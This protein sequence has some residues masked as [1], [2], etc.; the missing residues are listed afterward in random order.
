MNLL[1]KKEKIIDDK[2]GGQKRINMSKE[3]EET[4]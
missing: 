4:K 3:M 2:H 1:K